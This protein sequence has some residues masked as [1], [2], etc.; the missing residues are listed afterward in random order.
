MAEKPPLA[1]RMH[2]AKPAQAHMAPGLRALPLALHNEP[3][4]IRQGPA[5][6]PLLLP[7]GRVL[8]PQASGGVR[9]ACA[10]AEPRSGIGGHAR[11]LPGPSAEGPSSCMEKV[12]TVGREKVLTEGPETVLTLAMEEVLTLPMENLLDIHNTRRPA[13]MRGTARRSASGRSAA[14]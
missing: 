10:R 12:P 1:S 2:Y 11:L 6:C 9:A 13:P 8:P 4:R 5:S 14:S 3:L 7:A